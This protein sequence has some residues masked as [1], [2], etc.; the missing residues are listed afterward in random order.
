MAKQLG[1]FK[2]ERTFGCVT[3]Y[4]VGDRWFIRQKSSLSGRRVKT[5]ACFANTRT[6]A[7]RLSSGSRL[8]ASV[9]RSLPPAWKLFELYQKL[10]GIAAR[11]LKDGKLDNEIKEV[12][13]QQLYDWG[14]RKE[15]EYPVIEASSV[16]FKVQ[17]LRCSNLK[18]ESQSVTSSIVQEDFTQRGKG[19]LKYK[20]QGL[21]CLAP[22]AESEEVADGRVREGFAGKRLGLRRREKGLRFKAQSLRSFEWDTESK[23]DMLQYESLSGEDVDSS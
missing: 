8:A 16:T 10:T 17:G 15:I 11:L 21:R 14:Y 2:F 9:Y 18:S 5:A 20:V 3:F 4:R 7:S 23:C 6:S 22:D 12:L 13:E 1:R 19:S